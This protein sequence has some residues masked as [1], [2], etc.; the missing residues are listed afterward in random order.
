[1]RLNTKPVF[2]P[3]SPP[4]KDVA[5]V[6]E[7]VREQLLEASTATKKAFT[8]YRR[9]VD[10]DEHLG[11]GEVSTSSGDKNQDENEMSVTITIMQP[12]LRLMQ[13]LCENHN[14]EL[15]VSN[16]AG[17]CT[18][19]NPL[20]TCHHPDEDM[21]ENLDQ[22]RRYKEGKNPQAKIS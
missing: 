4:V 11:G 5:V 13:L 2:L 7:E 12:I 8:A 22:T 1:M 18:A 14:R 19:P 21:S 3:S 15:Q 20:L 17:L 6:T 16:R 9:E 10:S